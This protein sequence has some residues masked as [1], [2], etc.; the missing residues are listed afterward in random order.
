MSVN[1]AFLLAT[2]SGGLALRRPDLGVIA[3]GAKA[4]IVV[5]DGTSP[6]LLGWV[7]PVAGVI[8]HA[9][10]A[11]ITHVLVDGVFKKRDGKL[12]VPDYVDTKARFLESARR[13]Q[14]AVVSAPKVEANEHDAWFTEAKVV[15]APQVDVVRGQGTGYGPLWLSPQTGAD[16]KESSER[17]YGRDEL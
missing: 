11:D 2:R 7:D 17:K 9:S 14:A 3:P 1:Q 13:I 6:A 10:I 8:Q 5:W 12:T 16:A 4:D 15:D